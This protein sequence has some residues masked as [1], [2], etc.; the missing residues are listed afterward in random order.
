MYYITSLCNVLC[1]LYEFMTN[2]NKCYDLISDGRGRR[3]MRAEWPCSVHIPHSCCSPHFPSGVVSVL[4]YH[5]R[6]GHPAALGSLTFASEG[7]HG[8]R[9]Q[10]LTQQKHFKQK[11]S[12]QLWPCQNKKAT[13]GRWLCVLSSFS[14]PSNVILWMFSGKE[15][16]PRACAWVSVFDSLIQRVIRGE[17]S[18]MSQIH[19]WRTP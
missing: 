1:C 19:F 17:R 3:G 13:S 18:E 14:E 12:R 2:S 5:P 7:R 8:R 6:P 9:A 10:S 16:L 15:T 4:T 11:W